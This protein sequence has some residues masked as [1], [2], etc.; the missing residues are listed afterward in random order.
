M[1]LEHSDRVTMGKKKPNKIYKQII[2]RTPYKRK[3]KNTVAA[4]IPFVFHINI[5]A[6]GKKERKELGSEGN[7]THR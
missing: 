4:K 5:D 2:E 3:R 6:E 7:L 1:T